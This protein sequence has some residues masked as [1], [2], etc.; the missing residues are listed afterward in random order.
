V[1]SSKACAYQFLPYNSS[2]IKSSGKRTVQT[3]SCLIYEQIDL[4]L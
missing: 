3:E 1:V 4:V 2:G